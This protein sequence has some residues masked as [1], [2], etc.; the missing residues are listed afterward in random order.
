MYIV[1]GGCNFYLKYI[2]YPIYYFLSKQHFLKTYDCRPHHSQ[3]GHAAA[4]YGQLWQDQR[5]G[6]KRQER[7]GERE[8]S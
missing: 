3:P 8:P 2:L 5:G 6:R 1:T 4:G 7:E